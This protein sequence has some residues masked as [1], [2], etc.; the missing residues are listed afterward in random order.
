M[1]IHSKNDWLSFFP[2]KEPRPEQEKAINFI[3]DEF[4]S[5]KKFVCADLAT[6]IGKSAIGITIARY[7]QAESYILTTQKILQDQYDKD[8]GDKGR[9][10]LKSLKSSSNYICSYTGDTS[11]G[12]TKR[13][14]QTLGD[15]AKDKEIYKHCSKNCA[16]NAAKKAFF[17]ADLGVTNF[18]YYLTAS[19]YTQDVAP[20][21]L[22]IVDE[23]HNLEAELSRNVEIMF[24]QKFAKDTLKM[25]SFPD[26]L[27][28]KEILK[29]IEEKYKPAV[30]RK[31]KSLEKEVR[32]C[33][34]SGMDPT[35]FERLAKQNTM[36]DKHICKVNRFLKSYEEDNWVF[37]LETSDKGHKKIQFKPVDI[38]K[39]AHEA[40][41][42]G[43]AKVLL[44]SAT[45]INKD[46]FCRS[47]GLNINK[48]G[49]IHIPCPFPKE[50][51]KVHILP[52]GK[53][54]YSHIDK[55]LPA[56]TEMVKEILE[57][58]PNEKGIIHAVS[59][60]IAKY[61]VT[62]IKS[63][64]LITHTSE[65]REQVLAQHKLTIEPTVL[66]S[67]SMAEGVDLADDASRFQ[68]LC[69]IPFPPLNDELI[70]KRMAR[71]SFW[72]PYQTLKTIIQSLGRSIRNENDYAVSYIL[73]EDWNYFY[74]KNKFMFSE[75]FLSILQ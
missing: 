73:D 17:D 58:H 37:N 55:T 9:K 31:I 64:R 44:M 59:Y 20:R 10:L 11:C 2:F 61:L 71:D 15:E 41:F 43:T 46:A 26:C 51:R 5:G 57:Q 52:V 50:N 23:C 69:K 48:T 22:L 63:N 60:K 70:K 14:L 38:S 45:I 33:Y 13:V 35:V 21:H 24:S 30:Q 72:Y 7:L 34:I 42:D 67:P 19:Q 56:L 68:I 49:F 36:L 18:A 75:D 32:D 4:S 8:F 6:G 12:D 27:N 29:W 3:L 25:K 62:N 53:M 74:S 39:H 54:S 40:L 66:I 28:Q 16:Y 47:L 65:N 1:K